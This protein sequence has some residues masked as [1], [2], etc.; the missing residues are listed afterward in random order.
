MTPGPDS[1]PGAITT[2]N[3]IEVGFFPCVLT[4]E[5][6]EQLP[7][8]QC[9]QQKEPNLG[10]FCQIKRVSNIWWVLVVKCMAIKVSPF[11]TQAKEHGAVGQC[12][13]LILTLKEGYYILITVWGQQS[14]RYI[15]QHPYHIRRVYAKKLHFY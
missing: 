15:N 13:K 8:V 11:Q 14:N 12:A 10:A 5:H 1:R 3:V 4:R 2:E 6:A 7:V 9:Q